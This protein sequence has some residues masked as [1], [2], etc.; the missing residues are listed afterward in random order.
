M[1]PPD[2]LHVMRCLFHPGSG[3][4]LV[5]E[6]G[7]VVVVERGGCVTVGLEVGLVDGDTLLL[8]ECDGVALHARVLGRAIRAALA[9]FF[10][11]NFLLLSAQ[12]IKGLRVHGEAEE[13]L[14]VGGQGEVLDCLVPLLVEERVDVALGSINDTLLERAVGLGVF[15]GG[16][17]RIDRLEGSGPRFDRGRPQLHTRHVAGLRVAGS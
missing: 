5:E 3:A 12:G 8:E 13:Q 1:A 2:V 11:Q 7:R 14:E 15:N 9:E 16:R 6:T 17:N 10:Q 4:D